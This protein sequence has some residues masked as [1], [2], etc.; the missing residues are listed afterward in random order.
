M[1]PMNGDWK[2]TL[3]LERGREYQFRYLINGEQWLNDPNA[4]KYV[5]NPFGSENFVVVT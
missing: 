4:A 1:Q 5:P 2:Y 3:E